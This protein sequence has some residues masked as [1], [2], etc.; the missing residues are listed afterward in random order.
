MIS[1][2]KVFLNLLKS[3]QISIE[4]IEGIV[5]EELDYCISFGYEADI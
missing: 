4:F 5:L 1:T 2:P 3:N